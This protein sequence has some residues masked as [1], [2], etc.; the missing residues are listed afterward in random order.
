V[1]D[2]NLY[3]QPAPISVESIYGANWRDLIPSGWRL[4]EFRPP[5][6]GE[7]CVCP[8]DGYTH[9]AE[10]NYPPLRPRLILEEIKQ[11]VFERCSQEEATTGDSC[12]IR[13]EDGT[14]SKVKMPS[15]VVAPPCFVRPVEE[16]KAL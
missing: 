10:D 15:L 5:R 8:L 12:W 11:F 3:W 13:H 7:P 16:E 6:M 9:E 1:N 4:A 14:I 2:S